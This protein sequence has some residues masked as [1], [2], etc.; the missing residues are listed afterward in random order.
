MCDTSTDWRVKALTASLGASTTIASSAGD[1]HAV[2]GD[3]RVYIN[4]NMEK[5]FNRS[6]SYGS[7]ESVAY[8]SKC[9]Q[10]NFMDCCGASPRH[11]RTIQNDSLNI[12]G[13]HSVTRVALAMVVHLLLPFSRPLRLAPPRGER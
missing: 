5:V 12:S 1:W 8:E 2:V 11:P 13:T 4:K 6:C 3:A 7:I 10:Q 9:T